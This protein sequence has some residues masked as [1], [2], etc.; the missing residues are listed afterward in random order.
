[1][2][3]MILTRKHRNTGGGDFNTRGGS[4]NYQYQ[5]VHNFNDIG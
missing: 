3:G 4:L 5:H 2:V 1:M